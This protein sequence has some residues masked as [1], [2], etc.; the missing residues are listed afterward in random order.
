MFLS[1]LILNP[2]DRQVRFD[3]ARPY[4]M[5]RTLLNGGFDGIPKA[6]IG[7]VLFRVDVD[8]FGGSPVV[9]V[10]S[11]REPAWGHL[12]A[13]Y[14]REEAKCKPLEL[15]VVAGQRL[16][17]RLRANPTKRVAAKNERLGS[18]MVGKRVGLLTEADQ[19]AWLIRKGVEGGFT[20]P[21]EWV[22]ATHPEGGG[23]VRL[24]NFRVDAIPEGR[25]RN[26]KAGHTAGAFVAV[27]YEGVLKVTDSARF[28]A[29]VHAGV[30]SAK[31]YGYGLLSVGP[32]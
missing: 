4:E 23:S 27:R 13:E 18:L 16:R 6:D 28:I 5:H 12:P 31:G 20:I 3:S 25:D 17:F 15:V 21:G 32:A 19:I 24:P 8:R 2:R 29:T 1:Q 22:P 7:R 26:D 10:Q 11:E 14:L 30:G 9:L